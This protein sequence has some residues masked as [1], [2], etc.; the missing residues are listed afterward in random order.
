[1]S[2]NPF[3]I[4]PEQLE[5]RLGEQGLSVIDASWYLPAHKR[6]PRPEFEV[7]HIPG[8][9]FFDQD[10][11]VDPESK[12]PHTLP[13]PDVFAKA[14]GEL[15]IRE[16]DTIVIYDG[17]GLFSAPR[18][19]WMF[20]TFGAKDV[21]I[22]DGG[23]PAWRAAGFAVEGGLAIPEPAEFHASFNAAAVTD[24]ARMRQTVE[25]GVRQIA[26]AR[27]AD[28]FTGEAAEPRP[29]VRSGH[30]P[31]ARSV[32]IATLI[33][34]GRLKSAEGLRQA[35]E[36]A[37]I[38]PNAPTTT[39]CGSGVT[40]AVINLALATLDNRDVVLYDGSWTEWG[41]QSDTPV[42]TGPAR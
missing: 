35:F 34:T 29:G 12:L 27:P 32:P 21:R 36:A 3:L 23:F 16:S 19:W 4:T 42:E 7:A 17:L 41:S 26:D 22:L 31:G 20:R 9:V 30:M 8:A 18:A 2:N 5:P 25:A 37:G 33:E 13:S 24:L 6:F 15:G 39:S 28:R 11:V 10:A 1:M 14:A 40:A 38:D